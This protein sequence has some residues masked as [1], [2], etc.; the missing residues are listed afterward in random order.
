MSSAVIVD[1][2]GI[3]AQIWGVSTLCSERLS[4]GAGVGAY[5]LLKQR[6]NDSQG[7]SAD[8]RYAGLVSMTIAYAVSPSWRLRFIFNR[9]LA[10]HLPDTDV[11]LLGV[12]YRF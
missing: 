9:V 2:N 4:A 12:G 7:D 5:L 3:A 10:H 11:L 6:R 1:R 8:D